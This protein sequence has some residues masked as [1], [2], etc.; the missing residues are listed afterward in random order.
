MP[1]VRLEQQAL[2][3]SCRAGDTLLRAA[4]RAGIGFPYECVAGACG[5]CKFEL[6]AGQVETLWAEAGGLNDRDRRKGRHLA[7][8]SRVGEDC[9]IKVHLDDHCRPAIPPRR[10]SA[11]LKQTRDVTHDIREFVFVGDGAAEFLPGQFAL[12]TLPGVRGDRAYSMANL[13]NPQGEWVFQIRR[14]PDGAGTAALFDH[15]SVGDRIE[16][17]GPFGLAY[18][19]TDSPRDIVCISGG[20]G[21]APM[22]SIARG[23]AAESRLSQRTLHFF[24]GGRTPAD[25]CGEDAL[26]QLPGY[27]ET[28]RYYAAIS[29][30]A[31]APGWSGPSGFVHEL[32]AKHLTGNL[33]DYEF[34]LA[35]PPP[36]IQAVQEVLGK[37]Q[38]PLGQVHFDRFF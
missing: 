31:A 8:Q 10:Q 5:T 32:V 20:S 12:L 1:T 33:A 34:Y 22:L 27:G 29:D 7:C 25:L 36:M 9:S 2:S 13:P 28:L 6:L 38:V 35:G 24:F 17:D 15:L 11:A 37:H 23:K 18:L 30:P 19:R 3:F 26:K 14:R 4:L 16:L 21:V